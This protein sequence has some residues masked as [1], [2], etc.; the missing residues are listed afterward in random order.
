MQTAFKSRERFHFF[1]QTTR[2]TT[3]RRDYTRK[4]YAT[5]EHPYH[6]IQQVISQNTCQQPFLF[7]GSV[8]V[9]H[10]A[11]FRHDNHDHFIWALE[12]HIS[13]VL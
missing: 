8:C 9:L 12:C 6:K 2:L 4:H 1:I 10:A 13:V 3:N 5:Y 11:C 7:E